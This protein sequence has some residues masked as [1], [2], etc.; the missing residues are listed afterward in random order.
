M[1]RA[2]LTQTVVVAAVVG[3][4]LVGI[5]RSCPNCLGIICDSE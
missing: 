4:R 5:Y 2:S 3:N 1:S